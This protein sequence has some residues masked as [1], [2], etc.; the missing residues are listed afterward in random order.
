MSKPTSWKPLLIIFGISSFFFF[1]FVISSF[2]F[3]SK[4]ING[5][6][7]SAEKA[8]FQQSS[9]GVLEVNGVIMDSKKA[10]KTIQQFEESKDVKAVV[11]R[12][13]SP[14][15]AVGPSQEIYEALRKMSKPVVSSMSSVAASGGFYVAMASKKVFANPGTITGSIGVI[16]EFANLEKLY[17]W[18][19]VKRYVIK[20]GKFKDAGSEFREMTA[21]ERALLQGMV[22][23]VLV[24]FVDAV[25]EGRKLPRETVTQIADGRIFSGN[26]ALK[27][28]LVDQ[29][30]TF[31]DAVEEA[32]KLANITGK[33]KLIYGEKKK[34]FKELIEE[35]LQGNSDEDAESRSHG[36]FLNRLVGGTIESGVR[37]ALGVSSA[38]SLSPGI[39]WIWK[40]AM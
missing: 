29:L 11:V 12:I 28:K 26:Q 6:S 18:A 5:K 2:L 19:K 20:T 14:G 22:D 30:G 32:A 27:L 35:Q 23:D 33:P 13:N 21:E 16:M 17:E 39:Y 4:G 9:I 25:A 3:F 7:K 10:V 40:G 15:G 36:S 8:L 34:G 37:G 31:T 1:A 38:A 24:Q